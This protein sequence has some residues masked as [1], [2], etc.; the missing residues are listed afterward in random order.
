MFHSLWFVI[1]LFEVKV[2]KIYNDPTKFF[3]RVYFR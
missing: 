2:K 1:H 3:Q